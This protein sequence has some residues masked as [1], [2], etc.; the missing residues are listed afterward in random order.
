L[1]IGQNSIGAEKLKFF[2]IVQSLIPM[3]IFNGFQLEQVTM[4]MMSGQ[5]C[6]Q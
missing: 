2:S 4:S 1:G 6:R 5:I 3:A